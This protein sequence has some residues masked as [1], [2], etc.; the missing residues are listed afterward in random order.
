MSA[1][2]PA[3]LQTRGP[4]GAAG[5]QE[6]SSRWPCLPPREQL[7]FPS[8]NSSTFD[9]EPQVSVPLQRCI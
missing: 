3:S 5:R 7:L 2:G 6:Q 8:L 9:S 1:E 4:A